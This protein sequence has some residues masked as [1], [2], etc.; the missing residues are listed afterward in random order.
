MK[1]LILSLSL[2]GILFFPGC[3]SLDS[4]PYPQLALHHISD[5]ERWQ[6]TSLQTE[7]FRL[8][9]SRVGLRFP[10][11]RDLEGII[12]RQNSSGNTDLTLRLYYEGGT[13]LEMAATYANDGIEGI[14]DGQPIRLEK[15]GAKGWILTTSYPTEE[16]TVIRTTYQLKASSEAT[17]PRGVISLAGA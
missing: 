15:E 1:A 17:A 8:D 7:E 9:G 4:S 12:V 10:Q 13:F 14:R 16:S 3:S 5:G 11:T 6:V 2:V